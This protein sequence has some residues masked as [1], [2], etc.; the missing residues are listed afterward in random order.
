MGTLHHDLGDHQQAKEYYERALSVRL[1]KLGPDHVDVARTYHIMGSLHLDLGDHQQ[2]KEYYERAL[3]KQLNKLGPDH[4]DVARTSRLLG[5]VQC[6]L[7]AQQQLARR[8][9][10]DRVQ[11]I[12]P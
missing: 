3:S 8:V 2:A 6:V 12:Q 5:D 1:K 9:I 4:V 10:D 11:F 7:D